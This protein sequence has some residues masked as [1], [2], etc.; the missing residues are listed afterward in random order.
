[1]PLKKGKSQK[2]V[3]KNISEFHQGKTPSTPAEFG[4]SV[5]N[6]QAIAAALNSGGGAGS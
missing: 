4:R 3:S 1:M 2:V 5:V 6:K